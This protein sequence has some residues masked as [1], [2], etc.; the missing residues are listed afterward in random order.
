VLA[1]SGGRRRVIAFG[2]CAVIAAVAPLWV[3]GWS[4]VRRPSGQIDDVTRGRSDR[5]YN[6]AWWPKLASA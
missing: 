2:F 1:W 6:S 3:V 5:P 4:L